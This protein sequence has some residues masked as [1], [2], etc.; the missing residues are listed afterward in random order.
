[1]FGG[2]VAGTEGRQCDGHCGE[3]GAGGSAEAGVLRRQ[4]SVAT[5]GEGAGPGS[6]GFATHVAGRLERPFHVRRRPRYRW[7]SRFLRPTSRTSTWHWSGATPVTTDSGHS[8]RDESW[9][10]SGQPGVPN[11]P[12]LTDYYYRATHQ[13][14]VATKEIV[15]SITA[16]RRSRV[17]ISMAA[18]TAGDRRSR[19]PYAIPDDYD[20]IIVGCPWLDPAGSALLNV[21]RTKGFSIPAAPHPAGQV[22]RDRHR[23]AREMRRTRWRQ[24]RTDPEPGRGA[25][26]IPIRSS[27]A[28]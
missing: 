11:V 21:Q 10:Y 27:R 19:R 14:T 25:I 8:N 3:T 9:Y 17:R 23:R 20:G 5:D 12:K 26:S 6:A 7:Q 1:M 15:K 18:R 24:G 2:L 28:F 22:H 13:V 4:G 16:R